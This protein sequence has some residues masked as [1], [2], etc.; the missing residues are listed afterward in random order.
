MAEKQ[1]IFG[2]YDTVVYLQAF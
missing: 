2:D 1:L